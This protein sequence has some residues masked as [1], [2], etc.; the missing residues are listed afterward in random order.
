MSVTVKCQ[1]PA[2]FHCGTKETD[3]CYAFTVEFSL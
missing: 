1:L 3:E 2:S